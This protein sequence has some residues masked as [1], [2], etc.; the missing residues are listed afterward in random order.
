MCC[1][2]GNINIK[3]PGSGDQAKCCGRGT[4][5]PYTHMCCGNQ[6]SRR[7]G[8]GSSCCGTAVYDQVTQVCCSPGRIVQRYAVGGQNAKCCG[9]LSYNQH[10]HM[11]CNGRV[12]LKKGNADAKCCGA[13]SYDHHREVCCND[14]RIVKR[15][16]PGGAN[17]KCC[18]SASYDEKRFMCCN[19]QITT[20]MAGSETICCGH[21][22]IDQRTEVGV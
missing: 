13:I 2:S 17:A 14:G 9:D 12:T 15:Y 7:V 20:L 10:T 1:S 18:G 22:G 8:K 6:V 5:N 21:I 11:C 16:Y 3:T 4:F 19:N